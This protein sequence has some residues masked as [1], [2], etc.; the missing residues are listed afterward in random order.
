MDITKIAYRELINLGDY[1]NVAIKME[2]TVT[3]DDDISMCV[4]KLRNKVR[5]ELR[6]IR[7]N[8]E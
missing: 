5:R 1:N 6:F 7:E 8:N 2:A 4:T 3:E